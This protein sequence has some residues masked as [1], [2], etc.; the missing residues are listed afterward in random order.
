M[1][2]IFAGFGLA[3]IFL[4]IGSIGFLFLLISFLIGDIFEF[5]ELGLDLDAGNDFGL[6][7]SRVIAMVLTAFGGFGMIGAT[8]GFGG[9]F[10]SLFGLMGGVI[11]GS[12]VFYFGK[13]L[14]NKESA[15]SITREDL[16]G[17]TAQVTVPI[18]PNQVGQVTFI[19][20]EE[21]VEKLARSADN[22]EI[23][24]G[25]NVKIDSFAGD[26]IIV[27]EDT[28]DRFLLFLKMSEIDSLS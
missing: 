22:T 15:S 4:I 6:F 8:L 16:I 19:I 20:G 3:T 5:F 2:D 26:S 7:D 21:R 1:T 13:L 25:T 17:R 9:L 14:Y 28:G 11:F 12:I 18:F 10:S 24:V 23:K 27:K